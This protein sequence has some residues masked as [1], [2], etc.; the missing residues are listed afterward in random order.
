LAQISGELPSGKRICRRSPTPTH[1]RL[2]SMYKSLGITLPRCE[3]RAMRSPRA[4]LFAGRRTATKLLV[5]TISIIFLRL[6]GPS[7]G[8]QFCCSCTSASR[9]FL[10]FPCIS[11]SLHPNCRHSFVPSIADVL[12]VFSRP[13]C[14]HIVLSVY[15]ALFTGRIVLFSLQPSPLLALSRSAP[16]ILAFPLPLSD[17]LVPVVASP[18]P[19]HYLSPRRIVSF[20]SQHHSIPSFPVTSSQFRHIIL[21]SLPHCIVP[22]HDCFTVGL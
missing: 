13:V 17:G 11:D 10:S 18:F 2:S 1:A 22:A 3:I 8:D 4:S 14:C 16:R 19:A 9:R 21:V 6:Y 15:H 20:S 7:W 12:A 5:A